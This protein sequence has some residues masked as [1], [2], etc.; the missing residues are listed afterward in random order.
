MQ[1]SSFIDL[2]ALSFIEHL[3]LHVVEENNA[4]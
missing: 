4:D 3:I 1:E 2:F